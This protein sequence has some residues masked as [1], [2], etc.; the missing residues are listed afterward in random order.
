MRADTV[1]LIDKLARE[2]RLKKKEYLALLEN[3][4]VEEHVHAATLADKERRR[5]YGTEVFIRGLIEVGNICRNNCYYCG[6][7]ASNGKCVRYT[8][9]DKQILACCREGHE[10]G[11]RSFVLQGGEGAFPVER[12]IRI[13]SE[14]RGEFPDCAITLSLGEYERDEYEKMFNAGANR[15]LLRHETAD[16]KHYGLLHPGEMSYKHRV[17]CLES[18]REVGFTVG[19][20]FMVGSPFQTLE[21]ISS[22]L[23]FIEEFSPE[24]CGIGP[25]IPQKDTPFGGF[26]AGSAD[27]TCFLLSL[28][29]LIKPNILLPAT[30]ALGSIEPD[31]RLKG[32]LA[33]A[34]V[35]MPNLSPV[36]VRSK[37]IL[38]DN[39]LSTASESAQNLESLK[40]SLASIGFSVAESRGDIKTSDGKN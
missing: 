36:E 33:G 1:S 24:M 11:F 10:I 17:Q 5:I 9:T 6:I 26:R 29:R 35:V 18:L 37:Y 15:Y 12:V 4:S 19:C 3:A 38:Y 7:R 25:F 40:R 23:K 16:E 13:V 28:I 34:N 31:G 22:D 21:N 2:H 8:L 27:L 32:I 39:K 20:G 30:T 14:I